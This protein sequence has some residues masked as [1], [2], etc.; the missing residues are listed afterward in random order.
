VLKP[1]VRLIMM[2]A[3]NGSLASLLRDESFVMTYEHVFKWSIQMTKGVNH[4]HNWKPQIIHRDLKTLNL[5]VDEFYNVVVSD[6]GISR[7]VVDE[8]LTTLSKL[9]GTY[10][11]CAPELYLGGT[12]TTNSDVFS[13]GIILWEMVTRCVKGEYVRPYADKKFVLD[14]QVIIQVAKNGVRPE[15]E[16]GI[17]P[18]MAKLINLC[19]D[20]NP[21]KRIPCLE[22]LDALYNMQDSYKAN[23]QEWKLPDKTNSKQSSE[24]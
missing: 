24:M 8:N 14:F 9:R 23:P 19:W 20:T 18:D 3:E 10:S 11:Y 5:L 15:F 6:F 4:L 22:I 7:F 12:A 16:P 1:N 17:P 2:C 21:Q 13:I